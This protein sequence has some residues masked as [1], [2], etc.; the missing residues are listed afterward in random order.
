MVDFSCKITSKMF[1]TM[2]HQVK[3]NF[4]RKLPFRGRSPTSNEDVP[5]PWDTR[6]LNSYCASKMLQGRKKR[7]VLAELTHEPEIL[8]KLPSP[9]YLTKT[10]KIPSFFEGLVDWIVR[11]NQEIS[12]FFEVK[13]AQIYW[14]KD[15]EPKTTR[16]KREISVMGDF[17]MG[18]FTRS[19]FWRNLTR[20]TKP[21]SRKTRSP[22]FRPKDTTEKY[23][24]NEFGDDEDS[25][26]RLRAGR[27]L[28]NSTGKKVQVDGFGYVVCSTLETER[29]QKLCQKVRTRMMWGKLTDYADGDMFNDY[30]L[31][32]IDLAGRSL[33]SLYLDY[34]DEAMEESVVTP[35]PKPG[36]RIRSEQEIQF[37]KDI[38]MLD[39]YVANKIAYAC[40]D[41]SLSEMSVDY[42]KGLWEAGSH[43]SIKD[44]YPPHLDRDAIDNLPNAIED[45]S[46][47]MENVPDAI[48]EISKRTPKISILMDAMKNYPHFAEDLPHHLDVQKRTPKISKLYEAIENLP[49]ATAQIIW[50]EPL[51]SIEH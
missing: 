43:S 29:E 34:E 27:T 48:L 6:N 22:A 4:Q 26:K 38:V 50:D 47:S 5:E 49:E 11:V 37:R 33:W 51:T 23:S 2:R 7:N 18:D 41:V 15:K 14:R 40:K 46:E 42:C 25:K 20:Q 31:S 13:L 24:L 9:F 35:A 3:L 32:L 10:E 12:Q 36:P 44:R 8:P 19:L 28:E 16:R 30:V 45:L 1:Q 17:V 39:K 21:K